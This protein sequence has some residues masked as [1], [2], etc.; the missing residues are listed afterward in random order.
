MADAFRAGIH[1]SMHNDPPVSPIDPI[2][3]MWIAVNRTSSGGR[4]LG[5]DQAITPRQALEAYTVNAAY[6]LGMEDDG[7]TLDVGKLADF[8]V[9]DRNPLEIDPTKIRHVRVVATVMGGRIT[10][11]DTPEYDRTQPILGGQ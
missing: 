3:N 9:L 11:S 5:S 6:Q 1:P 8:V 4:V 10:Y 2:F 7:G